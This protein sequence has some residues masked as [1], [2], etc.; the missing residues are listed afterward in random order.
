[1]KVVEWKW[2]VDTVDRLG[3]FPLRTQCKY[4]LF[5]TITFMQFS[6]PKF[7]FPDELLTDDLVSRSSQNTHKSDSQ[8]SQLSEV[9]EKFL[10]DFQ[11]KSF[12]LV[13]KTWFFFCVRMFVFEFASAIVLYTQVQGRIAVLFGIKIMKYLLCLRG[14]VSFKDR[15]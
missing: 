1:M 15:K 14:V 13:N 5:H 2:N 7:N 9:I 8:R 6:N 12:P 10:A 3:T 4:L 11:A